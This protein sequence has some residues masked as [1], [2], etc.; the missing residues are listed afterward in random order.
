[1]ARLDASGGGAPADRDKAGGRLGANVRRAE[2]RFE[3]EATAATQA[4][5]D[6]AIIDRA[7][8]RLSS[9]DSALNNDAVHFNAFTYRLAL[10]T[11]NPLDDCQESLSSAPTQTLG[12]L[13]IGLS[14]CLE[15]LPTATLP[16]RVRFT[17]AAM[18]VAEAE[19]CRRCRRG[20][21]RVSFSVALDATDEAVTSADAAAMRRAVVAL[22]IESGLVRLG[23]GLK[24]STPPRV[25]VR[26][27]PVSMDASGKVAHM[28]V[29]V[30]DLN[31]EFPVTE[32][33]NLR[34]PRWGIPEG[35]VLKNNRLCR[36]PL[37]MRA[38]KL[39]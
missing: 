25:V 12:A 3:A 7:H 31:E 29:L 15:L 36:G 2:R 6:A 5:A 14:R 4:R 34:I 39:A 20:V 9:Y 37:L 30:S 17:T 23:P 27:Q 21:L 26:P 1:M 19:V 10:L 33:F 18:E 24:L 22:G 35:W 38:R 11:D 32:R 13:S 8:D 28:E 16:A